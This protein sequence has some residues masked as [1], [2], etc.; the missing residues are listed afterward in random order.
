MGGSAPGV[1]PP[2]GA[3]P[4]PS[5][6]VRDRPPAEVGVG[7]PRA[8]PSA[9]ARSG[10]GRGVGICEGGRPAPSPSLAHVLAVLTLPGTPRG[11]DR[12]G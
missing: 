12:L 4:E 7:E 2:P 3:H 11:E 1:P 6:V 10:W 9:P 5:G 8:L